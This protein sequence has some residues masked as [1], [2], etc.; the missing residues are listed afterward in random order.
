MKLRVVI[1]LDLYSVLLEKCPILTPEY[2]FLKNSVIDHNG[3]TTILIISEAN[4]VS[5]FMTW[6]QRFCP[7]AAG[8]ITVRIDPG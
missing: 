7:D 5:N 6:A 3:T 4:R 2:A 8:R 1:P